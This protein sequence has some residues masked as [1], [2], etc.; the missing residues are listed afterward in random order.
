MLL[1]RLAHSA[2][3]LTAWLTSFARPPACTRHA[4]LCLSPEGRGARESHVKLPNELM[5]AF[6]AHTGDDARFLRDIAEPRS[7]DAQ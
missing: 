1:G 7:L 6:P 2:C 3:L 4:A 5:A